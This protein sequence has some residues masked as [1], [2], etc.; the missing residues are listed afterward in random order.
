MPLTVIEPVDEFHLAAVV[1]HVD[2]DARHIDAP[3]CRPGE[4][5]ALKDIGF[6]VWPPAQEGYTF[7]GEAYQSDWL[8]RDRPSGLHVDAD[9][10]N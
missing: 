9:W 5:A 2:P 6:Q 3:E 4:S 10:P 1:Q 7:L 8:G